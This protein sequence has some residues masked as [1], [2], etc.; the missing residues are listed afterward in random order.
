MEGAG[1]EI[2]PRRTALAPF[3]W[4][5]IRFLSNVDVVGLCLVIQAGCVERGGHVAPELAEARTL[6]RRARAD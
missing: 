4:Q 6:A 5:K 3:G 2:E 1:K